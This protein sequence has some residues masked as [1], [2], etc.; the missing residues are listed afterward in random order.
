ARV[1]V[2]VALALAAAVAL[3]ALALVNPVASVVTGVSTL[4]ALV[5]PRGRLLLRAAP[6]GLLLVS[7]GYVVQVQ[8]RHHLPVNGEW[9][10]A[11]DKIATVSWIAILLL[12]ADVVVAAAQRRRG[13]A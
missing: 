6:A 5:L 11:F 8:L 4:A 12:A 13:K 1:P 9:V 2:P 10:Q 7:V 3:A